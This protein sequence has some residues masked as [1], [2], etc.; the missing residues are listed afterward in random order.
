MSGTSEQDRGRRAFMRLLASSPL[1]CHVDTNFL[2]QVKLLG[3]YTVPRV[4]VQVAATFQSFAGPQIL[5]TYNAPNAQVQ[6]S[7]GRPLAGGAANIPVNLISP[8]TL[9]NDQANQLDLRFAKIFRFGQRRT[10]VNFD[11][12]NALNVSPVLQQNN[13]YTASAWQ[14]PQRILNPRLFKISA[15]LDF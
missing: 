15:Q 5:A 9:Y 6:P 2:T 14:T 1:F 3:T 12:Y 10:A 13:T 7:L 4:D 11:L 8:G